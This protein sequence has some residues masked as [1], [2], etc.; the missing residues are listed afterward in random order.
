MTDAGTRSEIQTTGGVANWMARMLLPAPTCLAPI[1]TLPDAS[2]SM[3][4][5]DG[6]QG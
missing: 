2:T 3:K 5:R 4:Q 1:V 6:Q